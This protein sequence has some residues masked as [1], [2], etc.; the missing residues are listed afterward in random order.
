ME[1]SQRMQA[2][3]R[4]IKAQAP[5]FHSFTAP[6]G[7]HGI[8]TFPEFYTETVAGVRFVDWLRQLLRGGRPGEVS[9]P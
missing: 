6:G 3:L 4:Q 9:P 1:W 5:N 7:R 8:L 2:S